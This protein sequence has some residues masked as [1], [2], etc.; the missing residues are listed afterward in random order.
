NYQLGKWV[1]GVEGDLAWTN[2]HGA[3]ACPIGFFANCE[4]SMSWLSTV[5]GR[6][7]YAYWHRLLVYGKGGV[8]IA[9]DRAK[10]ACTADGQATILPVVGCPTS[11]DS[12]TNVGWTAGLGSEFGLT[13]NI[14][15][16][17]E[18]MYFDL[19]RDR[20]TI[21]GIPTDIQH[22]GFTSTI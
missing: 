22:S 9:Q 11:S 20:Y 4:T 18:T 15:V 8:A 5:T 2:A 14:S 16:K 3:R 1:L 7:G 21:A 6:I 17:S 19:G 13:R 10:A 12:K